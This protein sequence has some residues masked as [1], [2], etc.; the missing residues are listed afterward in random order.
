MAK[1]KFTLN[2]KP[3]ELE[4]DPSARLIDV[5]RVN[6]NLTAT[7]EGCGEGSCGACVVLWTI[8]VLT[9]A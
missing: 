5:L 6:L 4:V 1:I 2:D 3:V 7:K 8:K 9:P